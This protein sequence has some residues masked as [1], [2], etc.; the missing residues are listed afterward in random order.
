[1]PCQGA[2]IHHNWFARPVSETIITGGNTRVYRNVY[3]P[4]KVLEE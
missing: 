2:E 4:E 3:G 1:V